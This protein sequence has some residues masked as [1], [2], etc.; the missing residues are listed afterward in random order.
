[1]LPAESWESA[2]IGVGRR[3]S[4]AVLDGNRRVL[5][6][7]YELPR[8]SGLS[9]QSLEYVECRGGRNPDL[10]Y[11]LLGAP[12]GRGE[13]ERLVERGRRVEDPGTGFVAHKA[14]ENEHRESEW[15][16]P[17]RQMGDPIRILGVLGY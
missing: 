1:M 15:F 7:G 17:R 11:A 10:R 8:G 4:A 3:H 2:E 16:R 13:P 6:V 5:R 9:A 12:L 14:G